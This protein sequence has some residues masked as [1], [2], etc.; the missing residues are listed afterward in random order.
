MLPYRLCD[1]C[2]AENRTTAKFCSKCRNPLQNSPYT[3]TSSIAAPSQLLNHRYRLISK[4]GEGGFGAVYQV[5][6]CSLNNALRAVKEMCIQSLDPQEIQRAKVAFQQEVSLL[7]TLYHPHL[8]RVYDHFEQDGR[9]YLV[10]DFIEGQTLEDYL[11]EAPGE[12]LPLQEVLEIGIQLCE[13]LDYLHT[14]QPP[15]IF[16]DLKPSNVMRTLSGHLYLIDF[17]IARLFKPGK[18]QDTIA[19][20]SPGYAAP[21]Q[22]GRRQTTERADIYSLGATL[23]HLLSGR[24]PSEKPFQ[25]P[26]LDLTQYAPAGPAVAKLI[27]QMLEIDEQKRPPSAQAIEQD[28][29]NLTRSTLQLGVL[30]ADQRGNQLML[31]ERLAVKSSSDGSNLP[32]S[33]QMPPEKKSSTT[34][35]SGSSSTSPDSDVLASIDKASALIKL[36]EYQQAL[37][38][39]EQ[40]LERDPQNAL[41]YYYTSVA[42]VEL[43]EYQQALDACERSI[44]LDSSY[45]LA[46]VSK[47][48]ALIELGKYQQAY[49][50]CEQVIWLDSSC[51]LAYVSKANALIEL[52]KYQQALDVCEQAI[53]LQPFYS[54]AYVSKA[55]ALIELK[56]YQQALDA[57][58]RAIRLN[59]SYSLT[60]VSKAN[61]LIGLK[62]YQQALDTCEQAIQRDPQNVLA[63]NKASMAL[64][65]LGRYQQ[66]L[67]ACEQA[68]RLDPNSS[69]ARSNKEFLLKNFDL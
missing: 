21:E 33:S 56:R 8:P 20:G 34:Y 62:R 61:A 26:S 68:L 54:L 30:Q 31:S 45:S 49:N 38:A 63:H 60:Y 12:K 46:Y 39:C 27:E 57:C 50:V 53:P 3:P 17:G 43:G 52:G 24:D 11:A 7:A 18:K 22:H 48:N 55:R 37:D 69:A 58:E 36:K 16:R 59:S 66:A 35:K 1:H 40:A 41:A 51:T 65:E 28:L 5:A 42:L 13:V 15:I 67:D 2:G 10:M 29:Q 47:A 4:I 25:F 19:L 6:D 44:W 14:R 9:S 64:I 23:H 32:S